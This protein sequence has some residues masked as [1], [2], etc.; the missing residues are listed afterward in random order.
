MSF[1]LDSSFSSEAIVARQNAD[2][3]NDLGNLFSRAT[4]MVRK[5]RQGKVPTPAKFTEADH[6]TSGSG[7]D[8]GQ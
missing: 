2:L 1:G 3:A 4:A 8:H 5:Y 7:P 6:G